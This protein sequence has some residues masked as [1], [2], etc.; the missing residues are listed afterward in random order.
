MLEKRRYIIARYNEALKGLPL[1]LPKVAEGVGHAWHIYIIQT[2]LRDDLYAYLKSKGIHVQ[3][4]YI[5][6]H[7]APYYKK[8]GWNWGDFPIAESY[9]RRCLSLPVFPSLTE[10]GQAYVIE[11]IHAFFDSITSLSTNQ[12]IL[13]KV[14]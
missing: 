5:P 12:E 4:H 1:Q 3:V 11:H 9:Y 8:Q 2:D 10:A 7:L 13:G 6:I 14:K